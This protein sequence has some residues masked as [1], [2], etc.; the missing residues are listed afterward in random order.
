ML[1]KN[2]AS[3][4]ALQ[5]AQDILIRCG[6]V[7]YCVDQLLR[8]HQA[9][10]IILDEIALPSKGRVDTLIRELVTPVHRL[11]ETLG[12]SAQVG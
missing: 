9:A 7:S 4:G 6:A 2:I 12:L 11:F 10:Q 1:C 3:D 8:R 5:E